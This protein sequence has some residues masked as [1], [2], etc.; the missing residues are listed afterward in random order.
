MHVYMYIRRPLLV[1]GHQAAKDLKPI[2]VKVFLISSIVSLLV[3][4]SKGF[5]YL[6]LSVY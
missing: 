1:R 5:S 3:L 4:V 2:T 6:Q